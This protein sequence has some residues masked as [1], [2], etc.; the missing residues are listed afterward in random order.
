MIETKQ[1]KLIFISERNFIFKILE[2]VVQKHFTDEVFPSQTLR[3]L[4]YHK[5]CPVVNL[6]VNLRHSY[7]LTL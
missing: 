7:P 1:N 2:Y 4:W 5:D 3:F 6:F